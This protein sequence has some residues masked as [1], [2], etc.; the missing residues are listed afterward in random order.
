MLSPEKKREEAG[1]YIPSFPG[2]KRIGKKHSS[3]HFLGRILFKPL[4]KCL[5]I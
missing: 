1:V 2:P 4:Y 3:Q 5:K